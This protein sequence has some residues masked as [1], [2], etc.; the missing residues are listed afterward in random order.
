MAEI[1]IY[2]NDG[3]GE[4]HRFGDQHSG[5]SPNITTIV[6]GWW[7]G[8]GFLLYDRS[9]GR[10]EF[11]R[12]SAAGRVELIREFDNWR[13]TWDIIVPGRWDN[14]TGTDLLFYDRTAGE[15]EFYGVN[16]DGIME[17]GRRSRGWRRTWDAIVPGWWSSVFP[18]TDLLFYD[19]TAGQ[20]DVHSTLFRGRPVFLKRFNIGTNWDM[21]IPG[22]FAGEEFGLYTDILLYDRGAGVGEFHASDDRGLIEMNTFALYSRYDNWRHTWDIIVPGYFAAGSDDPYHGEMASCTDL[23]FYDRA[24]GEGEFYNIQL[25]DPVFRFLHR[26]T[27]YRR[28]WTLIVPGEWGGDE[29]TDLLFYDASS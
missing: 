7:G 19:R 15:G 11:Y 1:E 5:F 26:S 16:D 8:P 24:A 22:L 28:S 4:I 13:H 18:Y 9:A 23:L 14:G 6:Y 25:N 3:T 12:V 2:T 17:W 27:R 20:A 21:V 10:G 29:F